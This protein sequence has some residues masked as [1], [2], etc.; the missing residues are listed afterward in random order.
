MSSSLN[1]WNR[2]LLHFEVNQKA[3]Y[4][5]R[6]KKQSLHI[7]QIG[8]VVQKLVANETLGAF[9]YSAAELEQSVNFESQFW[10]A[11]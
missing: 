8:I 3:E 9:K 5:H 4:R 10:V 11:F 2:F 7:K 1:C 6:F